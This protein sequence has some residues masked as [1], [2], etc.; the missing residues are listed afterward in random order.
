MCGIFGWQLNPKADQ[1]SHIQRALA[2]L[3]LAESMETRGRDSFGAAVW[4]ESESPDSPPFI[5]RRLGKITEHG[6]SLFPE[7]ATASRVIAHTRAA[8]VGKVSTENS[9]PFEIGD[10]IGVHNG[11]VHNY[12]D[13]NDK[14]KR[15]FDVDSM[16]IFAH[17]ND[18]LDLD[19]LDVYGTI[20]FVRTSEKFANLYLAKSEYGS[21]EVGR[22]YESRGA[23]S[24][25]YLGTIFAS[26][27][28]AIRKIEERLG[29]DIRSIIVPHETLMFIHNGNIYQDNTVK[30]PLNVKHTGGY[31]RD[32]SGHVPL[33]NSVYDGARSGQS[34]DTH[35]QKMSSNTADL[36]YRN[37]TPDNIIPSKGYGQVYM[38]SMD[39][40]LSDNGTKMVQYRICPAKGCY[41]PFV[42]HVWG[43]CTWDICKVD[44]V[45]VNKVPICNVCGCYLM[46]E[47][48]TTFNVKDAANGVLC[49]TCNN[50]CS[51][52]RRPK[53]E[54]K[55]ERKAIS[56]AIAAANSGAVKREDSNLNGR[57]GWGDLVHEAPGEDYNWHW[58]YTGSRWTVRKR[59]I[60]KS[61]NNVAGLSC[62][63]CDKGTESTALAKLAS[64]VDSDD[65]DHWN[66][67]D[68]W[69]RGRSRSFYDEY[70]YAGNIDFK[71][72]TWQCMY[73][74][75][76]LALKYTSNESLRQGLCGVCRL[77]EFPDGDD[78]LLEHAANDVRI[79]STV[80]P[81]T[82]GVHSDPDQTE[83]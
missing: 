79:E 35:S 8:T 48:H 19:E 23:K 22:I 69:G 4:P 59:R 62:I 30:V 54:R 63:E 78:E 14:Y 76:R 16:H 80:V 50:I 64:S 29:V 17:L 58:W 5:F 71:G 10:V 37:P 43:K 72:R 55:S 45:C 27:L 28:N 47:I 52:R 6:S 60:C 73:C 77:E 11:M 38:P 51:D 34:S 18:N 12:K 41:D 21:L 75:K 15:N 36:I 44:D 46:S 67:Q 66:N 26:E 3:T 39:G 13:M 70:N 33:T 42:A 9:H 2:G 31:K 82:E 53:N 25:D 65:K 40:T 74:E 83:S 32:R 7:L 61:C 24:G 56:R 20:V 81:E 1:L 49:I 68:V 57:P